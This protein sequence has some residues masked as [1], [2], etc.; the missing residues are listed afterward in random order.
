MSALVHGIDSCIDR[1]GTM[2]GKQLS[3]LLVADAH[4]LFDGIFWVSICVGVQE[5]AYTSVFFG[6][7]LVVLI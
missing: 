1:F 3:K 7:C 5:S 4:T 2:F 6:K